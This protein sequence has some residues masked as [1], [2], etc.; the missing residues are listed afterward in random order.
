MCE[1][2]KSVTK[3][4]DRKPSVDLEKVLDAVKTWQFKPTT[5]KGEAVTVSYV[6]SLRFAAGPM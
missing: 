1:E 2:P 5:Y 6:I 4:L 3:P